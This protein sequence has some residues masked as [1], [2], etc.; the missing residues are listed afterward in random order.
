MFVSQAWQFF[1][2]LLLRHP[3]FWRLWLEHLRRPLLVACPSFLLLSLI[4]L[5]YQ[6]DRLTLRRRLH[7]IVLLNYNIDL[8]DN[9]LYILKSSLF[10]IQR[11]VEIMRSILKAGT[12]KVLFLLIIDGIETSWRKSDEVSCLPTQEFL[13]LWCR[14]DLNIHRLWIPQHLKSPI[15]FPGFPLLGKQ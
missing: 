13:C 15:N 7:L 4:L 1:Y 11:I 14:G 10:S 8:G 5:F 3:A 12:R 6:Q 2:L 9:L